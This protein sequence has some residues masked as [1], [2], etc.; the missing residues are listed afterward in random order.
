LGRG[1]LRR[2][3]GVVAAA[4]AVSAG[5]MQVRAPKRSPLIPDDL[6]ELGATFNNMLDELATL[7]NRLRWVSTDIAHDLRTPLTHVRQKLDKIRDA[8]GAS[9]EV[10]AACQEIDGDLDE[11]LRTFDAMLR[12]AEIENDPN[13]ASAGRV[14]LTELVSRVVDAYRPDLEAS[15][16]RLEASLGRATLKGDADL[17]AQAVANLIENA[18]RHTPESASIQVK[19]EQIGD[20]AMVSVT[21]DG[22]GIASDQHEAVL[23]RFHRLETSRTTSGSGLGLPIVAAIAKRHG[24][25]LTLED[26]QP[27][28]KATLV[29]HGAGPA[30]D[31]G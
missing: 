22:L 2:I 28:L 7:V 12:L 15:G 18:L 14:D 3:D 26:A 4:R 1:A 20:K 23:Q 5:Q 24:A 6:D 9:A 31:L 8:D 29:F 16:R 27:G 13:V 25:S 19:V 21:D 17:I 11:L 30:I 10:L